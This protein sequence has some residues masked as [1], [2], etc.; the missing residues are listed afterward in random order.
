M[1]HI[2]GYKNSSNRYRK[3]STRID[4]D[5]KRTDPNKYGPK[6]I[7]RNFTSIYWDQVHRTQKIKTSQKIKT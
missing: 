7:E 5:P 4:P 1:F 3:E 2:I 6:I